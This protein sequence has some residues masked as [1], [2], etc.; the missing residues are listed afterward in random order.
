MVLLIVMAVVII[1]VGYIARADVELAS[2]QSMLLRVQMDQL[3]NSGLEHAKGLLL[4]PQ[5]VSSA[6]VDATNWYWVG[7]DRN[8]LIGDSDDHDYYDVTLERD[9]TDYCTYYIACEAYRESNGEQIGWT[10]LNAQVRLDPCIALWTKLDTVFPQNWVLQGDLRTDGTIT[11]NAPTASLDGDVFATSLIGTC[12]GQTCDLADLS[13]SWPPVTSTYMNFYSLAYVS[14]YTGNKTLAAGTT[15]TGML[16]VTGSLTIPGSGCTITTVRNLPALYVGGDLLLTGA[17]NLTVTGLAVVGGNLRISSEIQNVKF[18]GGLCVAGTIKETTSDAS[19]NG[20]TGTL[21]G[22]PVWQTTG[23]L[24]GALRLDGVGDYVDC[25]SNTALDLTTGIT[26]AAWVKMERAGDAV[27]EPI[28]AKGAG[29]YA[30]TADSGNMKFSI[31]SSSTGNSY[32]AQFS[33]GSSFNGTWHHVAGTFDGS[34]VKIYL[35]GA[36]QDT[37]AYVGTI[38]SSSSTSLLLGSS[39]AGSYQGAIDDVHVYNSALSVADIGLVK[40]GNS[41]SGLVGQW[42]L[43]GPGSKVT[44]VADP[45]KASVLHCVSTSTQVY[46]S[47]A[48]GAFFRSIERQ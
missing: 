3:A 30:L 17:D 7:S 14:K 46:W 48:A 36:L 43:N 22:N 5:G 21:V 32:A 39:S 33:A 6:Q 9:T 29:T 44:I 38:A 18:L 10:G 13:L 34:N 27:C 11:S 25:S 20:L 47:P 31:C 35:D 16:S 23:A 26:V 8:R 12:V 4:R 1:S 2:G 28:V 41:A 42:K 40:N 19:G 37:V 45:I 24:D 15:I